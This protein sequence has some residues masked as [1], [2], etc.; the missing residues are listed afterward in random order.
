MSHSNKQAARSGIDREERR[1]STPVSQVEYERQTLA[2]CR[3]GTCCREKALL[4]AAYEQYVND[5]RAPWNRG[6]GKR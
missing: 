6:R 2:A 4:D 5:P 1:S 3:S